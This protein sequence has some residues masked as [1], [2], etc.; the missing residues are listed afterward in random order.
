M[1]IEG[2]IKVWVDGQKACARLMADGPEGPIVIHASAPL[3]PIR[4]LVARQFA[5]RG[6]TVSGEDPSFTS[7][8]KRIARRKALRRLKRVAPTAFKR[9]GLGPYLASQEL[10][11]RRRLRRALGQAGQPVGA[12]PIGPALPRRRRWGADSSGWSGNAC[13]P[14]R[15]KRVPRCCRRFQQRQ[16]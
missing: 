2:D 16:R 13:S 11:R 4:K 1:R 6:V 14:L 8:V 3:A 10:R 5:E 12:K 9:G 7:T 15:H